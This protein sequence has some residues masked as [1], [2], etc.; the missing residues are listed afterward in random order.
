MI[1]C[2]RPDRLPYLGLVN[3]EKL[4][5]VEIPADLLGSGVPP[6]DDHRVGAETSL[7]PS[8]RLQSASQ[9]IGLMA[10]A[11]CPVRITL[12]KVPAVEGA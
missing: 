1:N 12:R 7:A 11:G 4:V 9:A 10:G 6:V 8:T 3:A 5:S 2:R